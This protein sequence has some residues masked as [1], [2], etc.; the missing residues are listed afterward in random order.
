MQYVCSTTPIKLLSNEVFLQ[1]ILFQSRAEKI[2]TYLQNNETIEQNPEEKE[3]FVLK[4][5][6][7]TPLTSTIL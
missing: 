6:D 1:G 2:L 3:Y 4:N 5:L 7:P